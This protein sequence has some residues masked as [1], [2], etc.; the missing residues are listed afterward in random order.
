MCVFRANLFPLSILPSSRDTE[1]AVTVYITVQATDDG[2]GNVVVSV[3]AFIYH[4]R[5]KNSSTLSFV[6][7]NILFKWT[8]IVT[9]FWL[10]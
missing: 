2:T 6:R 4:T 1:T 3:G 9:I 5:S 8:L 10:L 7:R